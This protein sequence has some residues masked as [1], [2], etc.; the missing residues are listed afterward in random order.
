MKSELCIFLTHN[1]TNNFV[2]QLK[3]IDRKY[4]KREIIILYD[5]DKLPEKKY[6]EH[7]KII[8]SK[9]INTSYDKKGHTLYL[10]FFKN[11]YKTISQYKYFWIIE[12]DVHFQC[13]IDYFMNE[14]ENYNYDV[15]VAECGL[16]SFNWWHTN[17]LNG[18][19]DIYNIGVLGV[20]MR[21]SSKFLT[22]LIDNIDKVYF[23]YM[24]AIIPHIC[25][26]YKFEINTFLPELIGIM[27]TY[28]GPGIELVKKD[29]RNNTSYIIEN[30]IYHPIKL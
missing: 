28:G 26:K 18:F 25:K 8:P 15:L 5:N 12:N 22:N 11:N 1:F 2:S 29:I 20:V 6:F 23:G 9:K 3:K 10:S 21:F 27:N 14:H 16:R 7:I 13:G 19:E 24:E 30:K 17:T 4:N